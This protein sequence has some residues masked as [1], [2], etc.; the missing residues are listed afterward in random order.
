MSKPRAVASKKR[1][2]VVGLLATAVV[3]IGLFA[4]AGGVAGGAAT[5]G[6]PGMSLR[7]TSPRDQA[8][9]GRSFVVKLRTSE[10]IGEEDTGLHHVHLYYDGKTSEGEYDKVYKKRFKVT[11][12]RPGT[13]RIRASLRNAD[14]S[15]AGPSDKIAV[16][17]R[18]NGAA[19][20]PTT[21]GSTD[22]DTGY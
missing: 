14:H 12:L 18:A 2:V 21:G 1:S 17:V 16:T 15:D 19:P 6:E 5:A 11:E 22:S 13:H 9:V 20:T 8:E 10:Q 4:G 7:I 3:S